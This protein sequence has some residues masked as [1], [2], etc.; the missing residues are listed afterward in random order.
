M[1]IENVRI[2]ATKLSM[3][4]HGC[5]TFYIFVDGGGWGC[6]IGGYCIGHGYLGCDEDFFDA[7]SKGLV[8]MM[9]I[10]DVVGV[11]KWEDLPGKYIRVETDGWGDDI[12]KI[13]NILKD[14]WFDFEEFFVCE[15]SHTRPVDTADD[16]IDFPPVNDD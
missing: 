3:G 2:T 16:S 4:D 14:K 13:G 7:T 10:M 9:R 1:A 11:E 15:Q 8:A 6:G 12:H 5:L